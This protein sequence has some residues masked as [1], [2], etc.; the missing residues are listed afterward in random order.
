[1]FDISNEL[2]TKQ[3]GLVFLL[4]RFLL[5]SSLSPVNEWINLNI[6]FIYE[7]RYVLSFGSMTIPSGNSNF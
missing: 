2:S 7:V 3:D 1:M 5:K 4:V 6:G